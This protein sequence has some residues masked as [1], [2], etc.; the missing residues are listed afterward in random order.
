[1]DRPPLSFNTPVEN[2]ILKSAIIKYKKH[3]G[4]E[5]KEEVGK[6]LNSAYYLVPVIADEKDSSI[7]YIVWRDPQKNHLLTVFTDW[8]EIK[9]FTNKKVDAL[10]MTAPR[11]WE[12]ILMDIKRKSYDGIVLNPAGERMNLSVQDI[13]ELQKQKYD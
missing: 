1:M 6:I 3:P 4:K 13:L 8:G 10:V 2:S 12:F 7:T 5:Y 11:L 9:A